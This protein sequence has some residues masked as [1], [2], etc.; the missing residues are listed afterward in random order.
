MSVR[1]IGGV[2][3][4]RTLDTPNGQTTH[5][6]G[7]RIRNA[8]FNSLGANLA[9]ATV[10]DAFAG[11]G[12]LGIEALSRG[13]KSAVFVER[14]K[15]AQNCIQNNLSALQIL[16]G[17]LIK[18]PIGAWLNSYIGQPFTIIFADPPYYDP[19]PK[20]LQKLTQLLTPGGTLVVSWPDTLKAP[21]LIGVDNIFDRTYAGAH[22]LMYKNAA[23]NS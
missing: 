2:Y 14:D 10:L 11:T 22:I 20:I 1:V 7:E 4:G 19:Q 17:Q 12:A 3:G 16:N 6:M 5:P 18:A 21:E 8:I 13:A 15:I 23:P 9:D